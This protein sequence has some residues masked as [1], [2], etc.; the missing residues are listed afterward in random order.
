MKKTLLTFTF[1]CMYLASS[2]QFY[3]GGSICL[4]TQSLSEDGDLV[5]P[6]RCHFLEVLDGLEP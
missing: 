1:L 2:A 3:A 5:T 4:D 6:C